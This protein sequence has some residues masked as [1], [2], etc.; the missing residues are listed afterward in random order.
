[1]PPDELELRLGLLLLPLLNPE[2]KLWLELELKLWLDELP[3][4]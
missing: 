2:P 4:E 3:E 1:M